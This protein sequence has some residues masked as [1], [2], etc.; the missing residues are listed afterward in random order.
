MPVMVRKLPVAQE[1]P[2]VEARIA[3]GLHKIGLASKHRDWVRANAAGLSPTQGQILAALA[4]ETLT[5]KELAARLGLTLPTV[6][7]SVK[8]LVEKALV[9]RAAD[10]RHP[11][12]S[13]LSLSPKGRNLAQESK[14]WTDYL[15]DAAASL[16]AA[17]KA[18]FYAGLV[19]MIRALQEDGHVPTARMC[20]SC[21]HFRPRVREGSHP[22]HCA[23]VDAALADTDLRLDCQEHEAASAETRAASW[24]RFVGS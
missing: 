7:D 20:T 19:K 17:E 12:A 14:S 4:R 13:L 11:R 5:G 23:L 3:E 18:V 24:S 16:G 9:T 8:A 15:A 6:S 1:A 22:H 2:S 10:P 21:V